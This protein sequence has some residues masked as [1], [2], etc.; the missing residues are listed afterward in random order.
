[1]KIL[2]KKKFVDS[3]NSEHDPLKKQFA[4]WNALI[5]KKKKKTQNADTGN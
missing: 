5:K 4:G 1:M 2:L 3:V